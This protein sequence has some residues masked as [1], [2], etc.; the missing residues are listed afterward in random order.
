MK[1]K[2]KSSGKKKGRASKAVVSRTAKKSVASKPALNTAP[3]KDHQWPMPRNVL[4]KPERSSYVRKVDKTSNCVFCISADQTMSYETL[5]IHKT[6]HSQIVLNKY[7]YN[8]GHLL[9]LPLRHC[10]EMLQLSEIERKD[11]FDQVAF[12]FEILEQLYR[13]TGINMG[14]NHGASA[15]AGIP[16]HLHVHVI[17]RWAGDVNF[18]PLI[19][20]TKV[21]IESLDMTYKKM[22]QYVHEKLNTKLK[23]EK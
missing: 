2:K 15:G 21:V 22:R 7:P 12:A 17:P 4:Y 19:A 8:S 10:G 16:D 3:Q 1:N 9:V 23:E 11:L 5:C 13:P 14:M 20:E 6:Q 18:F